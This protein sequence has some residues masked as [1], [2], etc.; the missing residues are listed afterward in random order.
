MTNGKINANILLLLLL[1]ISY[2]IFFHLSTFG[3]LVP[4]HQI[5]KGIWH[6]FGPRG[7]NGGQQDDLRRW[8]RGDGSI[9]RQR[10]T[11]DTIHHVLQRRYVIQT[12][13][14]NQ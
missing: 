12:G 13:Q 10:F 4:A 6:F 8:Y 7:T 9:R 3:Q 5:L 14:E 2:N 1:Y 11:I